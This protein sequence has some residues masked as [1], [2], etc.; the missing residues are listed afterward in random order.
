[1]R[2]FA[3]PWAAPI[4]TGDKLQ[5]KSKECI[6]Q[7]FKLQTQ[8]LQG[9]AK[10]QLFE[11]LVV[12]GPIFRFFLVFTLQGI[13]IIEHLL[14][15]LPVSLRSIKVQGNCNGNVASWQFVFN[16]AFRVS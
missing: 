16:R 9:A 11:V 15:V 3:I 14:T 5:L 10:F 1:M 2:G 13:Q 6:W 4:E 7:G 12:Q 8:Y